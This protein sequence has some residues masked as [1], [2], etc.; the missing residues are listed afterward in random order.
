MAKLSL[1]FSFVGS[2]SILVAD[3]QVEGPDKDR[4]TLINARAVV[5]SIDVVSRL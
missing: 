2:S 4:I 1:S 3:A 5:D